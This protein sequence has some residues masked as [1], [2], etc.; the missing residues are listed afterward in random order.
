LKKLPPK[1]LSQYFV[2]FLFLAVAISSRFINIGTQSIYVDETWVV[3]NTNFHFED[4]SI[5]PKLF[6]YEPFLRL[7]PPKQELIRKVYDMHPLFQ[8]AALHAT[9]DL[10]PPLFFFVNYYWGRWFGYAE[11]TI[12]T[13][14]ALYS[15]ITLLLLFFVLRKQD[16]SIVNTMVILAFT[17]LSPIFLFYS[18]F[19]RPYALLMLLSLLS[20]YLCFQLILTSFKKRILIYYLLSAFACLYT[21]YYGVIVVASQMVYLFLESWFFH[22][23]DHLLKIIGIATATVILFLPAAVILI[24]KLKFTPTPSHGG[25][26]GFE[27]FNLKTLLELTLSFGLG[28][29]NS[30]I[31]LPFNI[32]VSAI[33]ITL[34]FMGTAFLWKSRAQMSSRFWLFFFLCPF[35]LI[36]I[37]NTLRPIFTVRNC[38]ILLIPYLAICGFGLCAFRNRILKVSLASGL[39]CVGLFFIYYGL[40]YGNVKGE[41]AWE[42]WRSAGAFVMKSDHSLPVYVYHHSYRDA[43]YYYVADMNRIRGFP[44]NK[45]KEGIED[46]NYILVVVKP[47]GPSFEIEKKLERELPF[48]ARRDR[49]SVTFLNQFPYIFVYRVEKKESP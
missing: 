35:L 9:S 38:L 1:N 16:I 12:R 42:D 3:P 34:F 22:K 19:A 8:V 37:L 24:L 48:L 32:A 20:S 39:T 14:A 46:Q 5:F 11:S 41:N 13:P 23:K 45:T 33:Q 44:E 43:L 7:P 36:V 15:M 29:S 6:T 27:F 40:S 4:N 18:N 25:H 26:V 49:Y 21:H 2:I 28:Y 47:E 17:I 31:E 10:H 30:T